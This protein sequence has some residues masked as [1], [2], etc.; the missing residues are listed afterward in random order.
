[1]IKYFFL[2]ATLA[3]HLFLFLSLK[4]LIKPTT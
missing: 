3:T 2:L 4:K 1:M